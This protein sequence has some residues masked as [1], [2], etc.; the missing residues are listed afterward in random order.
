MELNNRIKIF[1]TFTRKEWRKL[2]EN[3]QALEKSVRLI[4]YYKG[5]KTR[6]VN[7]NEAVE[8]LSSKFQF[9]ISIKW[10]PSLWKAP[11]ENG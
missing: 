11:P 1:Y 6:S 10:Q 9:P 7:Y 3:N 2:F 4:I 8:E 5:S